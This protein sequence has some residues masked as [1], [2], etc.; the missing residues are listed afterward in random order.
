MS[1]TWIFPLNNINHQRF[2][3]KFILKCNLKIYR[4][5]FHLIK[6]SG[7]SEYACLVYLACSVSFRC[8]AAF[9]KTVT[10]DYHSFYLRIIVRA[11][12]LLRRNCRRRQWGCFVSV[13]CHRS[14]K[15]SP[16]PSLQTADKSYT[17]AHIYNVQFSSVQFYFVYT[18]PNHT[19]SRLYSLYTVRQ[20]LQ[21]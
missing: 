10:S 6:L 2:V 8:T 5:H 7:K 11:C 12:T 1:L 15:K 13:S 16:Q 18:A 4:S 14:S 21:Y 9:M 17:P 19:K 20:T 3:N